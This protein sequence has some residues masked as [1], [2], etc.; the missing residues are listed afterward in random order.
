MPRFTAIMEGEE[1]GY[2]EVPAALIAPAA[3]SKDR[4]ARQATSNPLRRTP[5]IEEHGSKF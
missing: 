3:A 5:R 4:A 1:K 2:V